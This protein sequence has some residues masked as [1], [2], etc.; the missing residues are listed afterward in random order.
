MVCPNCQSN[1]SDKR[2]RCERC[3][4]DLTIYKKIYRVSNLYYNIGLEKAKVRDLSGAITAL[5]KSLELN[6]RNTNARNLLGLIYFEIG[7]TVA[8]LTEWVISR[9]FKPDENDADKYINAVQDNPTRLDALN[10]AI[11]RYNNALTFARQGSEDLAIIQLKRVLQLNPHFIRAYQLLALLYIKMGETEK[12][13][14]CLLKASRIDVSNTTTLKYMK[15]LEQQPALVREGA[16]VSAGDSSTVMPVS[17][18]KEEKPNVMA[19]VNL[20]VG[21]IIGLAVTVILIVPSIKRKNVAGNNQDYV[22]YNAGLAALE[23][24]DAAIAKLQEEN[25]DLQQKINE[26]QAELDSIE[27]PE[28]NPNLYD[29][30]FQA[31]SLYMDELSKRERDRDYTQIAQILRT[32]DTSQYESEEAMQLINRLKQEIFP[33]VSEEHYEK[34]YKLYSEYKYEEA[35]DELFLAYDYD[36]TNVDAI[37]FIARTYHRLEDY[38]SARTYY[39]IVI[40]NFPDS[41]RYQNAVSY[42]SR[43]PE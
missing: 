16:S 32:T 6:K 41:R 25:S 19:F 33:L 36:P 40:N 23:E 30:L 1:V 43:L 22:D 24:K 42:L 37:Y 35:L 29:T 31:S 34:G 28:E 2:N 4:H 10:Q 15:E 21:V 11:K 20:I 38:E 12:A 13:K 5:R 39:E 17:T 7:D 18:Y 8:A 9:H 27:I 26:L 3:G 14:K